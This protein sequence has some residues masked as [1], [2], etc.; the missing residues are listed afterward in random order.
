MKGFSVLAL[1]LSL[2][3]CHNQSLDAVLSQQE[4]E[5]KRE[6]S[7][8]TGNSNATSPQG[9]IGDTIIDLDKRLQA[10]SSESLELRPRIETVDSSIKNLYQ[11]LNSLSTDSNQDYATLSQGMTEVTQLL[12]T[13]ETD[14]GQLVQT[15]DRLSSES[16]A[17]LT[18][19]LNV[20]NRITEDLAN[21]STNATYDLEFNNLVDMR[22]RLNEAKTR[23]D[24][25][26]NN[27]QLMTTES[28]SSQ[29]AHLDSLEQ[30]YV[31]DNFQYNNTNPNHYQASCQ[32]GGKATGIQ[33]LFGNYV[34][35]IQ[36]SCG[37]LVTNRIGGTGGTNFNSLGTMNC[38][39]GYVAK[40]LKGRVGPVIG[41]ISLFCT[42]G[43]QVDTTAQ[44]VEIPPVG[45]LNNQGQLILDP[46]QYPEFTKLCPAQR[47]LTGITGVLAPNPAQ[48]IDA[49]IQNLNL[50]CTPE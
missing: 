36:L 22:R 39:N 31:S 18:E 16:D 10:L 14:A 45:G 35:S 50:I 7:S 13:T 20:R 5:K 9:S 40:G 17:I 32:N 24:E 2:T 28:Q 46:N 8:A 49:L 44:P 11:T 6:P 25:A 1:V 34:D 48:G 21:T 47:V 33:V 37:G 41:S 4:K 42:M 27:I 3:A 26:D 29:Q 38:P 15:K 23:I 19:I 12:N 43:S 30:L